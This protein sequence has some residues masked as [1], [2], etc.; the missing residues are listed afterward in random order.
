MQDHKNPK[1]K[2]FQKLSLKLITT[3]KIII[4]A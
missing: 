2:I 1:I 3:V 4:E